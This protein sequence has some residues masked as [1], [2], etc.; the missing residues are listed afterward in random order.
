MLAASDPPNDLT[1]HRDGCR[2]PFGRS[3]PSQSGVAIHRLREPHRGTTTVQ[4]TYMPAN[5][6]I[7]GATYRSATYTR[8]TVGLRFTRKLIP[9]VWKKGPA[10]EI[11][12]IPSHRTQ[13]IV[14][15]PEMELAGPLPKGSMGQGTPAA[16]RFAGSQR[17][18][19]THGVSGAS[20]FTLSR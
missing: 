13:Q 17:A 20:P 1:K 8:C 19:R 9:R 5:P 7:S 12:R 4:A 14:L 16:P 10:K 2:G 18:R 3:P 15:R 11:K 6:R